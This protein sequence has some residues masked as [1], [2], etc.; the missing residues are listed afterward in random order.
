MAGRFPDFL[1][2]AQSTITGLSDPFLVGLPLD[3]LTPQ[4]TSS[5]V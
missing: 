5:H 2:Y 1:S 3:L 4:L